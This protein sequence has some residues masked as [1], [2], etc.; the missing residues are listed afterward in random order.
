MHSGS[1]NPHLCVSASLMQII[2]ATKN[3]RSLRMCSLPDAVLKY[4]GSGHT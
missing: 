4:V 2:A 3:S 1:T